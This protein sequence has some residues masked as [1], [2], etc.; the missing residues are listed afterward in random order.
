M[1]VPRPEDGL[2]MM[3]EH[4]PFNRYLGIK[5][6]RMCQVRIAVSQGSV[7]V[8]EGRGVSNIHRRSAA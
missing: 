7:L 2:R 6:N 5:G 1:P 8:A 3:E 4:V